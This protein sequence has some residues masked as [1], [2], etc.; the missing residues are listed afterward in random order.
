MFLFMSC[1]SMIGCDQNN[2]FEFHYL[3]R[4]EILS[5]NSSKAYQLSSCSTLPQS[6]APR[7]HRHAPYKYSRKS[8]NFTRLHDCEGCREGF[9]QVFRQTFESIMVKV[10]FAEREGR[11]IGANI[12]T[13]SMRRLPR[14]IESSAWWS[15]VDELTTTTK[16]AS[17]KER[18]STQRLIHW[19]RQKPNTSQ[20][21]CQT[22]I[23]HR[24]Q[25]SWHRSWLYSPWISPSVMRPIKTKKPISFS[26]NS[27]ISSSVRKRTSV[28]IDP[29]TK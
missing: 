21:R 22:H 29:V 23:Q 11:V 6:F 9:S 10:D 19:K 15:L 3:R 17:F 7:Y 27:T 25:L 26:N 5:L 2:D 24:I 12:V 20:R 16:E 18:S 4:E 1:L 8:T 14:K 13:S 28:P